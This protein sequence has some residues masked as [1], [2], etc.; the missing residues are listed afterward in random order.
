MSMPNTLEMFQSLSG[1]PV[2]AGTLNL[3]LTEP[4]DY[5]LLHYIN[6]TDLGWTF[7]PSKY[8]IKYEGVVGMYY[9]SVIVADKY[10]AALIFFTWVGTPYID[11]EVISPHH[12][13]TTIGLKDGDII[14]FTMSEN[15]QSK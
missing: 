3:S 5:N 2:I 6:F 4:F 15:H 12:L 14:E 11:A 8:G 7:T 10:P 9:G 1:L 13:R